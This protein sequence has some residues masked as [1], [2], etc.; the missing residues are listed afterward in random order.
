MAEKSN[1]D[2]LAELGVEV[3][4]EKKAS[5]TPK[6]ERIIAGFEEIQRFF[7]EHG[8]APEHGEEKDIFERLYSTRLDQIRKQTECRDLVESLDHQGLLAG[9]NQI[10]EPPTEYN[11]DEELL[12][13]LGIQTPKEGDITY[14]KHV[15]SQTE[16]KAAEEIATRTPCK[17]FENFKPLFDEVQ[18]DI[19]SGRR[20]TLPFSKDGS[21]EAGNFFI[22]SGQKA[23]IAEVGD[24]FI[25]TDGR[26]EYRLRVIFDNGVESNQL[27]RSLQKRLWEDEAG[28]RITDP[29]M[30]PLFDSN[31]ESSD[32][33]SGTIYVLRSKSELPMIVANREVIH[34]IGVTGDT[35]K[36]RISNAALDPTYLMADVE[37]VASYELFNINRQ[38]LEKLLHRF[39]EPARL[40]IEIKDRFGNPVKPKEWFLVPVFVIDEVVEKIRDGS[41]TGFKYDH[42]LARLVE[43]D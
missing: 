7:S 32:A 1:R 26:K 39:F 9:A 33:E 4:E 16:K 15:K 14:L 40:D 19:K 13:E 30:G 12:A 18:E 37:I 5:R 35:V 43:L 41:I 22:L 24:E 23:Y 36:K 2:L 28:R 17:D 20:K 38:K 25:G 3:K 29:N 31:V 6:E 21:V 34:K 8:R 27:M 42:K 10:A 11:S